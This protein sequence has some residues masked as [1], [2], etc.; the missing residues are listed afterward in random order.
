MLTGLWSWGSTNP[1]TGK[2]DLGSDLKGP[3]VHSPGSLGSS[4]PIPQPCLPLLI[5]LLSH[6]QCLVLW[7]YV[8]SW[9]SGRE[10]F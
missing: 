3:S 5:P 9:I 4:L 8:G 6:H 7:G 2:R 10:Y 1:P